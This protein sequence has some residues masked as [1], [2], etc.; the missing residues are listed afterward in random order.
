MSGEEELWRS[1]QEFIDKFGA[2]ALDKAVIRVGQL[3]GEG[4][5]AG[6]TAMMCLADAIEF[7]QKE[8]SDGVTV[9]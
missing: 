3:L 5:E 6:A 4:D 7:L 2:D 9:H 8:D 1:A